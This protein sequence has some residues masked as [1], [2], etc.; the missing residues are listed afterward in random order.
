[1]N[2]GSNRSGLGAVQFPAYAD[3]PKNAAANGEFKAIFENIYCAR[4]NFG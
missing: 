1:V 4:L 3:A 2:S